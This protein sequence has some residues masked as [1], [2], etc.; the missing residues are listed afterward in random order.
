MLPYVSTALERLAFQACSIDHSDISPFRINHLRIQDLAE[1]DLC[2]G[3]CPNPV[4]ISIHCNRLR[5]I[6]GLIRHAGAWRPGSV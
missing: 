4:G 3:L 1:S 6:T 2:P 5:A